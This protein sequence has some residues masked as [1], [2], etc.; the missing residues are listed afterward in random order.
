MYGAIARTSPGGLA[1]DGGG[2]EVLRPVD[3]TDSS[4][5]MSWDLTKHMILDEAWNITRTWSITG[6]GCTSC[7]CSTNPRTGQCYWVGFVNWETFV[8]M[9]PLELMKFDL[10][11][12]RHENGFLTLGALHESG[13]RDARSE[14]EFMVRVSTGALHF[15]TTTTSS[16]S[17]RGGTLSRVSWRM[18]GGVGSSEAVGA[19]TF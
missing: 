17:S 14:H 10:L 16:C 3:V 5:Y 6:I 15:W 18:A 2:E 7:T 1:A 11:G 19:C 13:V 4:K 12:A 8:Y 9:V